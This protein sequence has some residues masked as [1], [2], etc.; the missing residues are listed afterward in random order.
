MLQERIREGLTFDDGINGHAEHQR[1]YV[2][3]VHAVGAEAQGQ[4]ETQHC[5][6]GDLRAGQEHQR[7]AHRA[8]E[9]VVQH[10]AGDAAEGRR[11]ASALAA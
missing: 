10:G 11:H 7:A 5:A 4:E 6:A 3:Y 2:E 9:E 1:Q 8:H